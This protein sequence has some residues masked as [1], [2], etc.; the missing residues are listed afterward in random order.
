MS[1]FS[2]T[3]ASRLLTLLLRRSRSQ[4]LPNGNNLTQK[5]FSSGIIINLPKNQTPKLRELSLPQQVIRYGQVL[6]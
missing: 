6:E 5:T 3:I 4:G 2:L 1:L